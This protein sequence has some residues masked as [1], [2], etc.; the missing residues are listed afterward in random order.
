MLPGMSAVD[1]PSGD[2][3]LNP[4]SGPETPRLRPRVDLSSEMIPRPWQRPDE[5]H[6]GMIIAALLLALLLG[7]YSFLLKTYWPGGHGGVDQNGYMKMATLI[8]DE[9]KL[10]QAPEDPYQFAGRMCIMTEPYREP[11]PAEEAKGQHYRIYAKYPFGFPLLAAA[12]RKLGGLDGQYIVNPACTV[13]ALFFAYLLFRQVLTRFTSLVGVILLACNPMTL[14][15]ANDANS[16]A[17]TL[18]CICLGFWGLV[19]YL[20]TGTWWTGLVGGLALGYAA[21]IRYTEALLVLPVAFAALTSFAA[22]VHNSWKHRKLAGAWSPRPLL[23]WI[24]PVLGWV[25]PIVAL[26]IVCRLSFG[27]WGRTG[28]WYCREDT[29]FGWKYFLGVLGSAGGVESS[30]QANWETF[31]LQMNRMGLFFMFPLA[32]VGLFG[33]LGRLP[34]LAV[35]ILLW[36]LP[37]ALLYMFYYWAP[38][39]E[40]TLGYMRFFH[41][42]IPGLLLAALWLAERALKV[43]PA[44]EHQ[45]SAVPIL[46]AG[47]LFVLVFVVAAAWVCYEDPQKFANGEV[48]FFPHFLGTTGAALRQFLSTFWGIAATAAAVVAAAGLWL[49]RDREAHRASLALGLGIATMVACGMNLYSTLGVVESNHQRHR[50]LRRIADEVR[51][52]PRGT[53]IF[54]ESEFR[55]EELANQLDNLGGYRVYST[56]LFSAGSFRRFERLVQ[57]AAKTAEKRGEDLEQREPSTYQLQRAKFY[58]ELLG[59]KSLT[60]EWEP[61]SYSDLRKE[62]FAVWDKT[63]ARNG[64]LVYVVREDR[65]RKNDSGVP[66]REGYKVELRGHVDAIPGPESK[67]PAPAPFRRGPRPFGPVVGP[68]TTGWSVYEVLPPV[69]EKPKPVAPAATT[70]MTPATEPAVVPP[71]PATR[72]VE[73]PPGKTI[74][75]F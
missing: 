26:L 13:L 17:S 41:S 11:T 4:P 16:H 44:E 57:D 51:K 27:A 19:N 12:G 20:R 24:W 49:L 32:I 22:N 59:R 36:V 48:N 56:S 52:L 14:V 61:R 74:F 38:V 37:S 9:G 65:P 40:T 69:R 21:T 31:L 63:F 55:G 60:G 15:Y 62:L 35:T 67:I 30:K 72:P 42:L 68:G 45:R 3:P 46:S 66:A 34:R 28:Y 33:M 47:T 5:P 6:L 73:P 8:A 43:E 1:S 18:L 25:I 58:M 70:R 75:D 50:N 23:R 64:R 71:P 10:G 2:I 7:G 29:G 54:C 53:V 39:Q